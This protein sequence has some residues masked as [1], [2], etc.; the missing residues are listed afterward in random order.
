[1]RIRLRDKATERWKRSKVKERE[2]EESMVCWKGE[3]DFKKL[4]VSNFFTSGCP[5]FK[6]SILNCFWYLFHVSFNAL[7]FDG[8]F[9]VKM[10]AHFWY[11]STVFKCGARSME[12]KCWDRDFWKQLINGLGISFSKQSFTNKLFCNDKKSGSLRILRS[13]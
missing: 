1:M 9:S 5:L 10:Y 2:G 6:R 3:W 11:K 13:L 4:S 8:F 12:R 7:I